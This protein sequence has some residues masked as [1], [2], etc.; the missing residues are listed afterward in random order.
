MLEGINPA[1]PREQ[2]CAGSG[3]RVLAI[4]TFRLGYLEVKR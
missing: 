2:H 4:L 3:A 1:A